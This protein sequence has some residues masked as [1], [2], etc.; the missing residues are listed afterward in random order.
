[1]RDAETNSISV[2]NI[3]EGIAG[4]GFP[5]L[6]Q[7]AS[8]FVLWE[9]DA[10]D[11]ATYAGTFLIRIDNDPPLVMQR[12]N[13]DFAQDMRHRSVVNMNGMLVPRPGNFRFRIE[14][15][16]GVA[17]EYAVDIAAAPPGVQIP[18]QA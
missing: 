11:A 1:V 2:F 18:R 7:H 14:L 5:L 8:F 6:V 13:V 3:F 10:T 17:A 15:E 4:V 16:G 9:R 12:I